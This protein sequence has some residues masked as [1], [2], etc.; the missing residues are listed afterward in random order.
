MLST[1]DNVHYHRRLIVAARRVIHRS[2]WFDAIRSF[3]PWYDG[4]LWDVVGSLGCV[5]GYIPSLVHLVDSGEDVMWIGSSNL[6]HVD[7]PTATRAA[8]E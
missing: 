4:R 3:W 6:Q 2:L 1:I 8:L 7:N 5:C